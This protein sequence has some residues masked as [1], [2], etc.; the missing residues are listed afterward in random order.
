MGHRVPKGTFVMVNLW[1]TSR[2]ETMWPEPEEFRPQRF[3]T[4]DGTELQRGLEEQV[5]L[6]LILALVT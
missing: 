3:L 6:H 1:S 2:D 5:C 4:P